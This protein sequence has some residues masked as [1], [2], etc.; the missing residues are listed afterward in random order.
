MIR[1]GATLAGAPRAGMRGD[2]LEVVIDGDHGVG[3]PQPQCLAHQRKV[4]AHPAASLL[5]SAP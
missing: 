5:R 2:R 1:D 4:S 3:G